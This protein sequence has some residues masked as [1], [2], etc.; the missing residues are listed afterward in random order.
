[1]LVAITPGGLQ[2]PHGR[3]RLPLPTHETPEGACLDSHLPLAPT[4]RVLS[5]LLI[6]SATCPSRAEQTFREKSPPPGRATGT[7]RQNQGHGTKDRDGCSV[8]TSRPSD[9][10]SCPGF[11]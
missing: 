5:T 9:R 1:M 7:P 11:L 2:Q 8:Q 4:L 3:A 10:F 6:R